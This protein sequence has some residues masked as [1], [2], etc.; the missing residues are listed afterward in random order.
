MSVEESFKLLESDSDSDGGVIIVGG[1]EGTGSGEHGEMAVVQAQRTQAVRVPGVFSDKEV[2]QL[3][4]AHKRLRGGCGA[5]A[6]KHG[7]GSQ[8]WS[9]CFRASMAP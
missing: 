8:R 9:T 1:G 2:R 3:L 5:A 7:E 4:A 6:K